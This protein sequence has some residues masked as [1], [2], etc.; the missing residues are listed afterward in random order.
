[1]RNA[2]Q[3]N[4]RVFERVTPPETPTPGTIVTLEEV[5]AWTD[6]AVERPVDDA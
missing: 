6:P 4:A 1:M 2:G 3:I 5:R